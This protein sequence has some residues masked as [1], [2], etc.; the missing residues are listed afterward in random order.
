[1]LTN[2]MAYIYYGSFCILWPGQVLTVITRGGIG[3]NIWFNVLNKGIQCRYVTILLAG[4]LVLK[5][6]LWNRCLVSIY[7]TALG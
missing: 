1:M 3:N 4:F 2:F 5:D 7:I 6:W